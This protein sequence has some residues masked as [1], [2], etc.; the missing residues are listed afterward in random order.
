MTKVMQLAP[1]TKDVDEE[2]I[3]RLDALSALGHK[4]FEAQK[5]GD[6]AAVEKARPRPDAFLDDMV[7]LFVSNNNA[8]SKSIQTGTQQLPTRNQQHDHHQPRDAACR[9]RSVDRRRHGAG[10]GRHH[11][12]DGPAARPHDL[13]CPGRDQRRNPRPR[14]ARMKSATWQK[15]SPSSTALSSVFASSGRA[16]RT[17]HRAK[18]NAPSARRRRLRSRR[19]AARRHGSRRR[20]ASPC[21]RRPVLP[22]RHR[23]RRPSRSAAPR[24]QRLAEQAQSGPERRRPARSMPAPMKSAPRPTTCR[25]A[26]NS[27]PPR[28][29]SSRLSNRS[30]RPRQGRGAPC[31]R[32]QPHEFGPAPALKNPARSCAMPSTPCSRSNSRRAR[33]PT[34]SASSTT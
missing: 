29:R 32:G 13:A 12:A 9:D 25:S 2:I 20:V 16:K 33:F 15:P 30:P 34:S 26:P 11:H 8:M 22:D 4:V 18:R 3:R 1:S 17:V 5:A 24:L 19:P 6:A 10:A 14:P 28:W 7:K 31:R 27:R 21:R 23:L